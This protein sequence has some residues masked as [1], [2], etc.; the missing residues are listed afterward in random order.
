MCMCVCILLSGKRVYADCYRNKNETVCHIFI[1]LTFLFVDLLWNNKPKKMKRRKIREH[2]Y[3]K[4][5]KRKLLISLC[6]AMAIKRNSF[7][8]FISITIFKGSLKDD[9]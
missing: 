9:A 2:I 6:S 7:H 5:I 8:V 4:M 1:P 3:K